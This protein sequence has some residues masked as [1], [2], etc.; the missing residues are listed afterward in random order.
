MSYSKPE[1]DVIE[2]VNDVIAAHHHGLFQANIGILMR[3]KAPVSAG[4]ATLGKARKVSDEQKAMMR[5]SGK[6]PFD[7]VIWF[8]F[9]YWEQLDFKQRRALAD[10]EL[11]HCLISDDG[12][13]SIRKHDIEEF[14]CIIE[15]HGFWRPGGQSTERAVQRGLGLDL[16]RGVVAGIDPRTNRDVLDQVDDIFDGEAT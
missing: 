4:M 2:I 10:H 3:D 14:H 6:E 13:F 11:C 15:R 5:L 16:G 7:F 9:D 12:E 8:A 1:E